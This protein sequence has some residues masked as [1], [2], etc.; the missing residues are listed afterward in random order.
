MEML[1]DSNKCNCTGIDISEVSIRM[2]QDKGFQGYKCKLP[3]LSHHLKDNSFDVCTIL[4][5]LEHLSSPYKT[6]KSLSTIMK[7]GGYIVVSVPD[8]SMKPEE[9]DEH[10]SSYN[11]HSLRG[12][13][14]NFFKIDTAF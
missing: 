11:I 13:L 12:L 10:V 6:I 5:T 14:I 8:D 2:V 4:E 7:N 1:R 3:D 9:H